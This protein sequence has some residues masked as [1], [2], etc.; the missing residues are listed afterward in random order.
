MRRIQCRTSRCCARPKRWPC[1]DSPVV[2]ESAPSPRPPL[3]RTTELAERDV[4]R[5]SFL[6][7]LREFLASMN[8]PLGRT[9][10]VGGRMRLAVSP[11]YFVLAVSASS[12]PAAPPP[13]RV[14]SLSAHAC[15]GEM[16][17]FRLYRAVSSL[18][19]YHAVTVAKRWPDVVALLK[20]RRV[21]SCPPPC[22]HWVVGPARSASLGPSLGPPAGRS[23]RL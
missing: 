10:V 11:P 14:P 6:S 16:D 17:L 5:T 7:S 13:S 12:C 2:T 20:L 8:A 4:A 21:R 9:P 23:C 15:A 22:R 19:G 3:Q 18:G 1:R